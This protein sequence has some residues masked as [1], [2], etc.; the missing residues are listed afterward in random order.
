M[1]RGKV[2]VH[3]YEKRDF[4]LSGTHIRSVVRHDQGDVAERVW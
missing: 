4:E 2:M 1:V 3:N